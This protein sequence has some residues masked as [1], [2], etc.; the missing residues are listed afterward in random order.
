VLEVRAV[1]NLVGDRDP[2]SWDL[3]AAFDAL[4]RVGAALLE[5]PWR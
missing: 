3:P 5:G 4:A 1:S 2:A